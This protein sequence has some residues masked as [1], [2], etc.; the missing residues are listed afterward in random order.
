MKY[1]IAASSYLNLTK[2]FI[3]ISKNIMLELKK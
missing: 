3:L 1:Y 2:C